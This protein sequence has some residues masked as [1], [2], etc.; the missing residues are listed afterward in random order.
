MVA[1]SRVKYTDNQLLHNCFDII[2]HKTLDNLVKNGRSPILWW[3]D[4]FEEPIDEGNLCPFMYDLAERIGYKLENGMWV[5]H[6]NLLQ[7]KG[8]SDE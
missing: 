8:Q 5:E 3:Q 1:T 7:K 6:P 4:G 2:L